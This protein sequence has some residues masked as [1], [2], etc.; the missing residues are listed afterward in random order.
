MQKSARLKSKIFLLPE[1]LEKIAGW[2]KKKKKIVFTNGCFDI[3]HLGHID[4]LSQ[5][6]DAGDVLIIGLNSD[7]S[8]SRLKGPSRPVNH[9]NA[10]AMMLA[11]LQLVDAIV[12]FEEDTPATLIEKILPDVLVKGKDYQV[13]EIA[14]H[15]VVLGHGGKVITI[16]LTEGYSTTGL[17]NKLSN[18]E[19]QDG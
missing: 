16:D 19:C 17:I 11:A 7:H 10:R 18:Q 5:A 8:V 4:Y 14:G 3:L 1:L 12:I 15:E 13:H 9:Q 2:R 6:A